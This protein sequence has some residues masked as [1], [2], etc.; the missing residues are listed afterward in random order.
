MEYPWGV[1]RSPYAV[2]STAVR[3]PI[4]ATRHHQGAA[5]GGRTERCQDLPQFARAE[6]STRPQVSSP[7]RS[8]LQLAPVVPLP[9]TCCSFILLPHPG[10]ILPVGDITSVIPDHEA[11]VAVL[12]EP[13]HLNWWV[14]SRLRWRDTQGMCPRD[15]YARKAI[16]ED[17]TSV[18]RAGVHDRVL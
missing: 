17:P 4:A 1:E 13:E 3:V 14:W 18:W 16:H 12:E 5:W 8:R 6:E 9:N 7:H 15:V 2:D 10:S 11:D